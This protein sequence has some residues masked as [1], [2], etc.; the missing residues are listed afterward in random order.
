MA[1]NE[2]ITVM[3]IEEIFFVIVLYFFTNLKN[4]IVKIYLA[5]DTFKERC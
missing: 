2:K 3:I 4:S 5:V 1:E